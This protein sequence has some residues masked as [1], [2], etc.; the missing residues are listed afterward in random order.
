MVVLYILNT[1]LLIVAVLAISM[2]F[3]LAHKQR[4]MSDINSVILTIN[5]LFREG[6]IFFR[7]E[8]NNARY[9]NVHSG[10]NENNEV[11]LYIDII[12][13]KILNEDNKQI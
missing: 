9:F 3:F 5:K 2:Q 11:N 8:N 1:I 10:F 7:D 13:D 12:N 4:E 6:K